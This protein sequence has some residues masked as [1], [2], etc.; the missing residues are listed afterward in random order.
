[1]TL[2]LRL[3]ISLVNYFRILFAFKLSQLAVH[4]TLTKSWKCQNHRLKRKEKRNLY[5]R[6]LPQLPLPS[7]PSVCKSLQEEEYQKYHHH[8]KTLVRLVFHHHL[9]SNIQK[10]LAGPSVEYD[11]P[12][13]LKRKVIDEDKDGI[14]TLVKKLKL[15]DSI[16]VMIGKPYSIE[17]KNGREYLS[18]I[19]DSLAC[20]KGLESFEPKISSFAT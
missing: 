17:S 16:K 4:L 9:A 1:M 13:T 20:Y 2:A 19:G 8:P 10:G 11:L 7:P 15:L 12:E 6:R 5:L 18:A 14:P 3:K